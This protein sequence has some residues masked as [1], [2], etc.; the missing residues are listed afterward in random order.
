MI[1]ERCYFCHQFMTDMWQINKLSRNNDRYVTDNYL[2]R[3]ND[4]SFDRKFFY[5]ELMIEIID[6]K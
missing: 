1:Y 5:Q 4:R 2:S 3:N 6:R